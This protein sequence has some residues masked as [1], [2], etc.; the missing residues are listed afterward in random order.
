VEAGGGGWTRT[1]DPPSSASPG[2]GMAGQGPLS[3][4]D[5]LPSTSALCVPRQVTQGQRG[6]DA[7]SGT[8]HRA[9][10]LGVSQERLLL[11]PLPGWRGGDGGQGRGADGD[12]GRTESVTPSPFSTPK[13]GVPRGVPETPA[14]PG[15][16]ELSP[17]PSGRWKACL[18]SSQAAER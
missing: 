3:S 11:N 17:K 15:K 6:Q 12:T 10:V 7:W 1:H 14:T 8:G 18:P 9:P 2:L 16:R 13:L 4:L 5:V